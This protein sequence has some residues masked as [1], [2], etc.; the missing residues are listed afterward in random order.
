MA[1]TTKADLALEL[2][3]SLADFKNHV[4]QHI[5]QKIKEH[6]LNLSF[7]MLEVM[8]CLWK[9][10]GIIQQEIADQTLRDKSSMTYLIDNL[11]KRNLVKRTEDE[12]DR[13]NK[14]IYLTEE[15]IT[16]RNKLYPWAQEVYAQAISNVSETDLQNSLLLI[17]QMIQ[18][19]KPQ[20]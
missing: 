15:G 3:R 19:L 18:N 6:Q 1:T 7:E 17:N 2:G 8:A 13:R 11:V 4:R 14:L 12:K 16:L 5:Q 9:E 20:Q 10:D